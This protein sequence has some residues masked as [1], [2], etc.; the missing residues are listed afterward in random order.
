MTNFE[1][2]HNHGL[3]GNLYYLLKCYGIIK[4]RNTYVKGLSGEND[5]FNVNTR[6]WD[7]IL[8][9]DHISEPCLSKTKERLIANTS[10]SET[11][12]K[13]LLPLTTKQHDAIND[14]VITIVKSVSCY[15]NSKGD[16]FNYSPAIKEKLIVYY[17]NI[18]IPS[19]EYNIYLLIYF[20]VFND[21]PE[22]FFFGPK[23]QNDLMIFNNEVTTR[24]GCNSP[25][26]SRATHKLADSGNLVAM[27]EYGDILYYGKIPSG[28]P[29]YQ[30]ALKY[31]KQSA[32]LD[33]RFRINTGSCNPLALWC[34]AYMFYNYRRRLDLKNIEII[35]ELEAID[36]DER[37]IEALTLA[38]RS[39]SLN[40]NAP[41]ANLIGVIL[42]HESEHFREKFAHDNNVKLRTPKEYFT[43]AAQKGYVFA[44]NNLAT[45]SFNKVFSDSSNAEKHL[46]TY[47]EYLEKAS[48]QYCNWSSNR[49]GLFYLH[50]SLTIKEK[51]VEYKKE[52]PSYRNPLKAK[53]YFEKACE[54]ELDISSA[55][56]YANLL[57]YFR[58]EYSSNSILTFINRILK[59]NN[60]DAT[61]FLN[62]EWADYKL[63]LE[64]SGGKYR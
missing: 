31:F 43:E 24:Y 21:L 41:A 34:V 15:G 20:A 38:L 32:G 18:Q 56:A 46:L 37:K 4:N 45:L 26:G 3:L 30:M 25:A 11:I 1:I 8:F 33:Y 28:I 62:D 22:D 6:L 23:F 51:S 27:Y 29:N 5:S 57:V 49:L 50:G 14:T 40:S 54:Y 36:A 61:K 47:L 64:E 60:P 19:Y 59:I 52:F 12:N 17:E 39:Y 63:M 53:K 10:I 44:Y 58:S 35:D 9:R 42:L 7:N 55:W 2:N 13:W 48:Q 16:L